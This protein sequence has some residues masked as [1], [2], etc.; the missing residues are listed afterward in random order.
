MLDCVVVSNL[1]YERLL[2]KTDW[3]IIIIINCN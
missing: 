3:Y 1:R 2:V